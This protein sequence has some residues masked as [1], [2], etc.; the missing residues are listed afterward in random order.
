[1]KKRI[2]NLV[3]VAL[4][5]GLLTAASAA[6]AERFSFVA[7]GDAP[8]REAHFAHVERLIG[9][10]NSIKPAFTL[11]VG[12]IKSGTSACDDAALTRMRDMFDTFDQPLVYTPGDNEWTDCHRASNGSHDPIER[13]AT[14]RRTFYAQPGSLGRTRMRLER[15]SDQAGFDKFVENARWE[16]SGVVFATAHIVGSNNNLQR[17][18]AAVAEYLERNAANLAWIDTTFARAIETG[19]RAVVIAFQG[20]PIWNASSEDRRS[21]FTDT[22]RALKAHSVRFG[23]PVLIVHGDLHRFIVDKPLYEGRRL[24]Y[25]ATRLMVFGDTEVQGVLVSV[26]P[27]DPDVF[28]FRTLTVQENVDPVAKPPQ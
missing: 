16:R 19:A 4:A 2:T 15:Q 27:D 1:M 26:D 18:Q 24:I 12:D 7:I 28:S 23:R 5:T 17:N 14:L 3:A 9:R 21:G 20:D 10:I 13:L 8:Y 6:S 25:N 11:H 22:V